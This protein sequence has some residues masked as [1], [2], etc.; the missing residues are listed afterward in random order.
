[1]KELIVNQNPVGVVC[2]KVNSDG[3]N[4]NTVIKVEEGVTVF[5]Y[6]DGHRYIW[7]NKSTLAKAVNRSKRL[8]GGQ[9][10]VE[11]KIYSVDEYS[12]TEVGWGLFPPLSYKNAETGV[13]LEQ[14]V[15]G[16]YSFKIS[17]P[18]RFI[19]GFSKEL[20]KGH[21]ADKDV[22]ISVR[23]KVAETVRGHLAKVMDK[24]VTT[25]GQAK[26]GLALDMVRDDLSKNLPGIIVTDLN[27]EKFEPTEESAKHLA[28]INEGR[29]QNAEKKVINE[30]VYD[31]LDVEKKKIEIIKPLLNNRKDEHKKTKVCPRCEKLNDGGSV[32][33]SSCGEKL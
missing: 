8:F 16:K 12:E 28:R 25:L 19:E 1:M 18:E 21:I 6:Y 31:D 17:Q 20:S 27:I 24:G 33:C 10:P 15:G 11:C 30:G 29:K 4:L 5:V 23:T 22:Q 14:L 3:V 7:P 26:L 9:K 32:Y 13:E 2:Q